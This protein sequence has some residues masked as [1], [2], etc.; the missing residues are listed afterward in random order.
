MSIPFLNINNNNNHNLNSKSARLL[1]NKQDI[2]IC[3]IIIT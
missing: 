3:K 1:I 2:Y